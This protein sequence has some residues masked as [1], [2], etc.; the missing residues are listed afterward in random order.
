MYVDYD[1][2]FTLIVY[3]YLHVSIYIYNYPNVFTNRNQRD[4]VYPE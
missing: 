1:L 2:I 3:Y 4:R